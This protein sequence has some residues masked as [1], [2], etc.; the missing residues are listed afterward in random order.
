MRAFVKAAG[1]AVLIFLTACSTAAQ[2]PR[3]QAPSDVVATVGSASITLS[4]VDEHA[5]RQ[6][7]GNFGSLTLAQALFEARRA[8]LD[9]IVGNELINREAKARG[10][11]RATLTRNEIDAKVSAPTE[12]EVAAWYQA[13]PSRVQGAA[14]DKVEG[15][16]KAFLV[17]ERTQTARK[18]YLDGLKARTAV[19]IMLEPPRLKVAD[20]GRPSRGPARAQVEIIE[21]SDFQ[22]PFCLSAHPTVARVLNTYGDRVRFVYRHYPLPNHPNAWPAAEAAACAGEQ[23]KFW[24]YHDRLFDN[25]SRLGKADLKKHAAAVALDTAKFD[26]CVDTHKYKSDVDADVAAGEEAGV[27]GT[28]AFFIN[29]RQ[30]S[31]AQPFEAFKRLI[32]EE[33]AARK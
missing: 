24:E 32:D 13:N 30:L 6:A 1:A 26:A 20:A 11:D 14:L 31:G 12:V 23:G 27:S 9:E 28:P 25:Q 15:P 2:S 16:I 17:Q 29:G 8:A 22:C 33:L 5:L 7:A 4:D 3:P 10:V 19:T 21:F 18:Q